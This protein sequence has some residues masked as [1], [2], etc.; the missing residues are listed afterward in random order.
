MDNR[1]ESNRVVQSLWIGS[2]LSTMERLCIQSFLKNGHDFHLYTYQELANVPDGTI[3]KDANTIIPSEKIFKDNRG[4]IA[5]F[6]DWF[7]YQLLYEKG[8]WW[9]DMDSVCLKHF[10]I[11]SAYCFSS[12]RI[13]KKQN[14]FHLNVGAIKSPPKA[15]F[16]SDLLA[17]VNS[18]DHGDITWGVF[19]PSLFSEVLKNYDSVEFTQPP[20]TFCPINWEEVYKLITRVPNSVDL[21]KS[22]SIHLWNEIWGH[23]YLCKDAEYHPDSIYEKLKRKYNIT[24]VG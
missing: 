17:Y 23:G 4:G 10:D 24:V 16:L 22:L 1:N 3:L 9:V 14:K 6:A 18:K 8:G 7:R 12:E 5:S 20:E 19:G 15:E 13:Y 21:S 2:K 11:Q